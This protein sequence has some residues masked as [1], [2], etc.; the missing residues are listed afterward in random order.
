MM[1]HNFTATEGKIVSLTEPIEKNEQAAEDILHWHNS[2]TSLGDV[3]IQY[4]N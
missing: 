4:Q 1:S 2:H 3:D